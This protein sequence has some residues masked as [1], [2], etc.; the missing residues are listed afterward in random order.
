MT[1]DEF[2]NLKTAS[3]MWKAFVAFPELRTE[4]LGTVFQHLREKEFEERII[5][6]YGSYDPDVHYEIN[7][8][9]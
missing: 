3:E 1:R 8:R 9:K 4:E 5:K 7:K 6:C 2:L